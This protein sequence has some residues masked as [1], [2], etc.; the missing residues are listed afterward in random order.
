MDSTP[1]CLVVKLGQ[2]SGKNMAFR[3]FRKSALYSYFWIET[4]TNED[5]RG[6]RD[7]FSVY[8]EITDGGKLV[9]YSTESDSA[10]YQLTD[11]SYWIE[12]KTIQIT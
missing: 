3:F 2:L 1:Y 6:A 11:S 4:N 9:V 8:T 12:G 7:I 10:M 5:N